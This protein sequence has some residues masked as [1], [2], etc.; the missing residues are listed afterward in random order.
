MS[1]HHVDCTK[2]IRPQANLRSK[3]YDKRL[4]SNRDNKMVMRKDSD[5]EL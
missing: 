1:P 3:Q 4:T 2:F 5:D